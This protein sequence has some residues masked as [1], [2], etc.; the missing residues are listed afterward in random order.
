MTPTTLVTGASRGL[1][2]AIARR[3]AARGDRVLIGFRQRRE[4]AEQVRDTILASGGA[5][6]LARFDLRD[7]KAID[8][9]LAELRARLGPITGLVNAAALPDE[10]MFAGGSTSEFDEVLEVDLQGAIRC[11]R[12]LVRDMLMAGGGSVVNVGSVMTLRGQVGQVAYATA[13]GGLEAFTRALAIEL[14]P[15]HVRVN[16]VIAGLFDAGMTHAIPRATRERWQ[17]AIPMGRLGRAEE[18]AE[19]VAWLSSDAASYVT[20]HLMVV[21]G[22]L[23][24]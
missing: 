1:G 24:L 17:A 4:Q 20:G 13:K 9:T 11:T 22:G 8:A 18:L 10:R 7:A 6:E 5:A 15:R 19:V 14:A 21:D 16:A 23:S 2:A 12:A 3:L